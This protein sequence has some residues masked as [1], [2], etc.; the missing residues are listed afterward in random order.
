[1]QCAWNNFF[2]NRQYWDDG[3]STRTQ[4]ALA[5][6]RVQNGTCPH[7]TTVGLPAACRHL[8]VVSM[9]ARSVSVAYVSTYPVP[10]VVNV[11]LADMSPTANGSSSS[12]C[13]TRE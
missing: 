4:L 10:C 6:A 3:T 12:R 5:T 1:M 7:L 13:D 8:S 9:S 2:R 11:P